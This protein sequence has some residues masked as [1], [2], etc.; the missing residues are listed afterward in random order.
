MNK[1]LYVDF[2]VLQTV[3]PSCMNRDDTGSPKT[4][5]YGGSLRARVSSQ[6][7]KRAMRLMFKELFSNEWV[8]YRTRKMKD[9]VTDKICMEHPDI[10]RESAGKMAARILEVGGIKADESKKDVLFFVS[11]LQIDSLARLAVEYENDAS[12][13]K[14]KEK[15]K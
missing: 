14:E 3:P 9:L 4:A 2:H 13:K 6:A 1:N 11:S 10:N 15:L 8:G 5:V 12:G 7:S